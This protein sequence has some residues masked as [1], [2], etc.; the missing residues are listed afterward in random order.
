MLKQTVH[1]Y[2]YGHFKYGTIMLAFHIIIQV[3]ITHD[4]YPTE[5]GSKGGLV[6]ACIHQDIPTTC[7]TKLVLP[8]PPI[9]WTVDAN[10]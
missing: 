3:C 5:H 4:T 2:E 1:I 8:S 6:S 7:L 9:Q 10:T